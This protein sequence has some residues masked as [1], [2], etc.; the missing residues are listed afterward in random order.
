MAFL[1]GVLALLATVVAASVL[2]ALGALGRDR[3]LG[4]AGLI[5]FSLGLFQAS[6][7]VPEPPLPYVLSAVAGLVYLAWAPAFYHGLLELP[8]GPWFQRVYA[9]LWGVFLTLTVLGLD[10]SRFLFLLPGILTLYF[11]MVAWGLVLIGWRAWS[12][13]P[14]AKLTKRFLVRFALVGAVAVPFLVVDS[15][16]TAAGWPGL[17]AVDNL[18][19]PVFL[20]VLDGLILLEA[21]R[22]ALPAGEPAPEPGPEWPAEG[23]TARESEIARRILEGASAKEIAAAL[24]LSPKT[25]ENHTYRIYQKLGV[26]S[27]L[28]F[29]HRFREGGFPLSVG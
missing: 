5:L 28:Q 12:P 2:V 21:R 8:L 26:R 13:V 23:L 24:S 3:L 27:R 16:G 10:Q 20:L 6:M 9:A 25:V 18:A 19:L 29:Y 17:A 1:L 15:W 11:G 4:Q 14:L 7:M 22:W